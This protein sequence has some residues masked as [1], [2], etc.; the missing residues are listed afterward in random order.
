VK[1]RKVQLL[2]SWSYVPAFVVQT[3]RIARQA[4]RAETGT[5]LAFTKLFEAVLQLPQVVLNGLPFSGRE[6]WEASWQE[7][8]N[9]LIRRTRILLIAP[10]GLGDR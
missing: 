5:Q 6:C 10:N 2:R 9:R 7:S 8:Q 3:L 1:S 4:A